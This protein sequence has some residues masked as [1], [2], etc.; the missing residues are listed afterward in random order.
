MTA[1]RMTNPK[2][3]FTIRSSPSGSERVPMI[4]GK[5][6]LS[7]ATRTQGI[8]SDLLSIS[9][10]LTVLAGGGEWGEF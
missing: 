4:W 5:N 9:L 10:C 7:S 2:I 6:A 3:S 8:R 1:R